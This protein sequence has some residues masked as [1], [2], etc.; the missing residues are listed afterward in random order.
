[1]AT[2]RVSEAELGA[3]RERLSQLKAE[4]RE[5]E[6]VA[7]EKDS[8]LW[9][10]IGPGIRKSIEENRAKLEEIQERPSTDPMVEMCAIKLLAGAMRGY[11]NVLRLVEVEDV[12]ANKR[13][14][15]EKLSAEIKQIQEEQ[16]I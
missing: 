7:G 4:V 11:K 3:K 8:K 6:A 15:A 10:H 13:A 12:I 2:I 16:G 1:M 5:L 9:Q 14:L